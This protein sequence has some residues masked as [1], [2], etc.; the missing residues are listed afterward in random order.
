MIVFMKIMMTVIIVYMKFLTIAMIA[1]MITA[2][3]GEPG[4]TS[5]TQLS[6]EAHPDGAGP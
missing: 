2:M 3:F 4:G 6:I 5:P 1:F